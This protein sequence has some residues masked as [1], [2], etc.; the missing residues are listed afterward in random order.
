MTEGVLFFCMKN[1][2]IDYPKLAQFATSLVHQHLGLPVAIVTDINRLDVSQQHTVRV[3]GPQGNLRYFHEYET[4]AAWNNTGREHSLEYTP[5]D[6]TIVL[7]VDYLCFSSRLLTY[8]HQDLAIPT[9]NISFGTDESGEYCLGNTYVPHL[10]ASV[11]VFNRNS[12]VAQAFFRAYKDTKNNWPYYAHQFGLSLALYRNDYVST[13]AALSSD[14]YHVA[15]VYTDPVIDLPPK[16]SIEQVCKQG[17]TVIDSR[18]SAT[19]TV[20]KDIH[21]SNKKSLEKA[22]EFY[23]QKNR[24]SVLCSG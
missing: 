11:M 5:F 12:I 15:H 20:T 23:E 24:R 8:L 6:R 1:D 4:T 10:W 18:N 7:D 13:V 17:A 9:R 19:F 14:T 2:L 21:V 3:S 16:F 22:I